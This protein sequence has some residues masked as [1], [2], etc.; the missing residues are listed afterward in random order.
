MARQ[1]WW[2]Q[3]HRLR[4]NGRPRSQTVAQPTSFTAALACT[5]RQRRSS[6][7]TPA[8]S[9]I[10]ACASTNTSAAST[11]RSCLSCRRSLPRSRRPTPPV[12]MDKKLPRSCRKC[13]SH[14]RLGRH[15]FRKGELRVEERSWVF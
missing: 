5:S 1:P 13:R 4:R 11:P 15:A 7:T 2:R 8:P 10:L 3:L 14:F 6:T 12:A 9:S